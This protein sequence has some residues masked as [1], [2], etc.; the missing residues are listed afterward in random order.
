MGVFGTTREP[1]VV[2]KYRVRYL[3]GLP[4]YPKQMGDIEFI[5]RDDRFS[6]RSTRTPMAEE[7]PDPDGRCSSQLTSRTTRS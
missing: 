5:V 3:G 1:G 6:F 4:D 7:W 2:E